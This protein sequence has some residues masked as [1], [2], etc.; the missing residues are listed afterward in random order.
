VNLSKRKKE[1]EDSWS[2]RLEQQKRERERMGVVLLREQ[3]SV[4][5]NNGRVIYYLLGVIVGGF[6]HVVVGGLIHVQAGIDGCKECFFVIKR[7]IPADAFFL[8]LT[9]GGFGR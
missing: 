5:F 4:C 1:E 8:Q 6:A 9:P 2:V 3:F 7:N